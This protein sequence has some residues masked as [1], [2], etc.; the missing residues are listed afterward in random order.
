MVMDRHDLLKLPNVCSRCRLYVR[1]ARRNG[2]LYRKGPTRQHLHLTPI[3]WNSVF[4]LTCC[5][6]RTPRH[7]GISAP[8]TV[9][10][11]ADGLWVLKWAH[12]EVHHLLE[13]ENRQH[14]PRPSSTGPEHSHLC[15]NSTK[16]PSNLRISRALRRLVRQ[17][18]L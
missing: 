1:Q 18:S 5:T 12:T 2:G 4:C 9:S 16:N 14:Y 13:T 10:F 15:Q 17:K 8:E 3:L 6:A 11:I 7:V